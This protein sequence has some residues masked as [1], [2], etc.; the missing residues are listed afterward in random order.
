MP[1]KKVHVLADQ[2]LRAGQR[3]RP[4]VARAIGLIEAV[5]ATGRPTTLKELAS[6]QDIPQATAFRLCQRL[7]AA[8]YLV[9]DSGSRR[10]AVGMRLMRLGLD[11]VRNSGPMSARRTILTEVVDDIEE[12]CNLTTLVGTEVLYLDRVETRWPLRVALEPGS[13]VPL[14]CTASGKLLLS[15]M[16]KATRERVL[17]TLELTAYTPRTIV[18]AKV[19]RRD[20]QRIAKR[21]FST[22][23]EE[24]LAGLVA[25]AVPIRDRKGRAFAAIA[26]HAP[27]AR[28]D[29][30]RAV[31]LVPRL[32]Q[33][34]AKLALTFEA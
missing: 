17:N 18:E 29:L 24:F 10:Y 11:I 5:A 30:K 15:S 7:E 25:V 9:R 6:T 32:Q 4:A 21:G 28:L 20:L 26:C 2:R 1:G 22:D 3:R 19:L 12:T 31:T 33:A 13:R 16:P 23:N 27:V 8:G 34:A 14:H